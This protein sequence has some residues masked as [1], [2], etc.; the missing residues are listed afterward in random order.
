M[1]F[2]INRESTLPVLRLELIQDGRN[3]FHRFFD[4]IQNA[5]ITFSMTDVITGIKRIGKKRAGTALVTPPNCV[6]DEYY[7]IYQFTEKETEKPGR[8]VGQFTINFLDG[9]GILIVP[10]REE[11]FVNILEGSIKK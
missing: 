10:I 2:H 8:F 11:L 3:D 4:L 5:N 6:T 7:L 1:E 9:T